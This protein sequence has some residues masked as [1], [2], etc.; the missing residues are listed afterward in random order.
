MTSIRSRCARDDF[1]AFFTARFERLLKQ[2]E[3]ATGKP[4]NRSADGR[5]TPLRRSSRMPSA[6][7]KSVRRVI[8]AGESKVVEFKST[9]WKNLETGEKDPAIEWSVPIRR[10]VD[11][12]ISGSIC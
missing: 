8:A 1:Q 7:S 6:W 5:T 4:V 9:A 12:L 11:E 10:V 2:I 3:E